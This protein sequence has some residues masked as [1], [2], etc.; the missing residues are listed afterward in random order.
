MT[1]RGSGLLRSYRAE[2]KGSTEAM[3]G[4]LYVCLSLEEVVFELVRGRC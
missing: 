4:S 3:M 1:F 2:S